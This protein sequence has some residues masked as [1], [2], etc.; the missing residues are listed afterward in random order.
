ME[1]ENLNQD[2]LSLDESR[3]YHAFDDVKAELYV[4]FFEKSSI[5]NLLLTLQ[6]FSTNR[7]HCFEPSHNKNNQSY[8]YIYIYI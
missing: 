8:I 3:Q 2:W 4:V 6:T 5:N 7:R 1:N